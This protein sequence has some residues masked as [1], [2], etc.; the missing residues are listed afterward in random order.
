M[1]PTTRRSVIV[2]LGSE[3][4]EQRRRAFDTYVAIYWKPL[5]KY[6]RV[7]NRRSETDAEDQ[8][9]AFLARCF[10]SGSLASYDATKARFRTFLRVLFDRFVMNEIKA[11]QRQKRGGGGIALDFAHAAEEIAREHD[12]GGSPEGYFQRAWV[13]S[14]FALAVGRL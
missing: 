11:S 14:G 5:Y 4:D 7:T 6:L 1:F 12:R 8:T 2:A 3:D 13:R 10:E 9:Q